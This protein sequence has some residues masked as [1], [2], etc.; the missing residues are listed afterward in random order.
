MRSQQARFPSSSAPPVRLRLPEALALVAGLV[1]VAAGADLADGSHPTWE[2]VWQAGQHMALAALSW[3]RKTPPVERMSWGGMVLCAAA[4]ASIASDRMLRLQLR[5]ISPK[6]F[7]ERLVSRIREGRLDRL[8]ATDLCELNPSA[9]ARVA[10]AA[11]QRWGRPAAELERAVALANRAERERFR[12]RLSTLRRIATLVPLVGLL[13]SLAALGQNLTASASNPAAFLWGPA[14]GSAL[15]PVSAGVTLAI[16][17]LV[18]YDGLAA[19][20]EKLTSS[21]ESLGALVIDA[22]EVA[23][24]A[25]SRSTA[26]SVGPTIRTPH[27]P[28]STA[29]GTSAVPRGPARDLA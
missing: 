22:I 25:E 28:H 10:L 12:H 24:V 17:A 5:R 20:I 4:G 26:H 16:L 9:S 13:G 15:G 18:A 11:I 19:R 21:L 2:G 23:R 1:V 6:G 3:Y 7:S 8:K 29:A 27:Q 14:V